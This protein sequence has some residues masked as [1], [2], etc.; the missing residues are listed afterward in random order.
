M[1]YH[2]HIWQV[3]PRNSYDDTVFGFLNM[4]FVHV[5]EK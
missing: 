4:G 2:N 1:E 5:A 3:L